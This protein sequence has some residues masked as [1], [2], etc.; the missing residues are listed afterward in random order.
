LLLGCSAGGKASAVHL[1]ASVHDTGPDAVA[2]HAGLDAPVRDAVGRDSAPVEGGCGYRSTGT[3]LE[4]DAGVT[5]CMPSV[6]CTSETC[7]PPLGTCVG[8]HCQFKNGYQGVATDPSAWATYYCTLSTGGCDGVTQ[9]KP[10]ATTASTVAAAAGLA[11]CEGTDGGECVG[12]AA[13]S[14]MVV[15]NSEEAKDP[16]TGQIVAA[17]GLGL[18]EASGLCYELEGPGGRATV[19]LTDRCGGYCKCSGSG[20]EECGPC[21]NAPD[22]TPNCSCVGTEPGLYTGCCGE[23]CALPVL[24]DCDWC[25]SNNHPHFDLDVGT[26]NHVCGASAAQGSCKLAQA[27][28]IPCPAA[29][30]TWPP[31][32]TGASCKTGSFYCTVGTTNQPQVPGTSCCCN[33]G[34]VPQSDG[35]CS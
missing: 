30:T 22:M 16:S 14:P 15:G 19:A 35:T 2:R 11:L 6:V 3:R 21:V 17:W 26:F 23:G 8:G 18:T 25:A 34:L 32:G 1:D 12:I 24:Q 7:P 13:S 9:Q 29:A 28:F 5:L 4:L 10:A 33:W 20:F 31:G 27:R